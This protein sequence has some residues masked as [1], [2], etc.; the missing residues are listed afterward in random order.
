MAD[1]KIS[2]LTEQTSPAADDIFPIVDVEV[3]SPS[4][5]I[6]MCVIPY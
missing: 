6:S 3:S 4:S 1:R 5:G 2:Q